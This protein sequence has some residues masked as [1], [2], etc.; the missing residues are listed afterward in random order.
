MSTPLRDLLAE[1]YRALSAV[2]LATGCTLYELLH[3]GEVYRDGDD[4][5]DERLCN[6]LDRLQRTIEEPLS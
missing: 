1:A 2:Q 5:S 6:L 3:D 4:A